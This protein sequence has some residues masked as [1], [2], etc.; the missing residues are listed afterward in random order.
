MFIDENTI[1][2]F[3]HIQ[4]YYLAMK[5]NRIAFC[6]LFKYT[7]SDGQRC[8]A[9]RGLRPA[10]M[11]PGLAAA[12]AAHRWSWASVCRLRLRCR[13]AARGSSDRLGECPP[14]GP[15]RARLVR[16]CRPSS[17]AP[18]LGGG[19][20]DRTELPDLRPQPPSST[21]PR[22]LLRDRGGSGCAEQGS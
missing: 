10:R 7:D 17:S 9:S 13:A 21:A 20:G 14:P 1:L 11:L 19:G 18:V 22:E 16:P 12:A 15:D 2:Y 3:V 8:C 4:I 6:T 5:R